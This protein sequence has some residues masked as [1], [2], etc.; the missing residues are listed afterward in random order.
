MTQALK[1][2]NWFKKSKKTFQTI[3]DDKIKIWKF[4]YP[5]NDAVMSSWATHFRNL[6]CNDREIDTL[7][8]GTNL[9]RSQ[10]LNT[11]CFFDEAKYPGPIIKAGDFAETLVAVFIE[12]LYWIPRLRYQEKAIR[13]KST[14][15]SDVIDIEV[16]CIIA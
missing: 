12:F 2:Q 3:E 4:D 6:Y 14:E 7:R 11:L 10:Y 16:A 9:S 1:H 13:N 15:G 5:K 8:S